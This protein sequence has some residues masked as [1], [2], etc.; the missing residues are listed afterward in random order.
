MLSLGQAAAFQ[1]DNIL[2]SVHER[3][4]QGIG[5]VNLNLQHFLFIYWWKK[6][7]AE[8]KKHIKICYFLYFVGVFL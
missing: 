1:I 5:K 6:K 8:I 4:E 7:T 2:K 3:E